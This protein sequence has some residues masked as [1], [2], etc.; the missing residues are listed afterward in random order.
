VKWLKLIVLL[1]MVIGMLGGEIRSAHATPS[2]EF[3][4]PATIDV[5]PYKVWHLGIDNYF[6]I[7]RA[8]SS[9]IG[10]GAFATDVGLTVGVLPFEKLNLEVGVDMLQPIDSMVCQGALNNGAVITPCG[11]VVSGLSFNFKFGIPE[12]AIFKGSPGIAAG[13]LN[14]GTVHQVTDMNI[15]D[16]IVG[17]TIGDLGRVHVGGYLGSSSSALMHENG[18]LANAT[19]NMGF[20][21]AYDRGFLPVKDKEGK[22]YNKI[23]LGADYA[24][25]KNYIGGYGAGVA[26]YFTKDISLLTGPVVFNDQVINGRWKWSTQLDI[27]F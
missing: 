2:T 23:G 18:D 6:T 24:S 13:M 26:F 19:K 21:V 27:N 20:M 5:Q 17:K 16:L 1:V 8:P 4:T 11:T 22:E 15:A 14:I 12:D 9:Q 25:G 10:S 3:W 7:G